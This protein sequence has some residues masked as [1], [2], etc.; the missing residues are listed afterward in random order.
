MGINR[1]SA[2][3]G[4]AKDGDIGIIITEIAYIKKAIDDINNKLDSCY[5]TKAE[6]WP[7]KTVVYSCVSA[8]GL[9]LLA[10]LLKNLMGVK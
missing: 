10:Y 1:L 8:A 6:H 3:E 9:I 4:V 5:V 2:G 7:V